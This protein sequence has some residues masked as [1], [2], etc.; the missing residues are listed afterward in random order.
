[1]ICCIPVFKK[2]TFVLAFL[3]VGS[4]AGGVARAQTTQAP[5]GVDLT[6][7][8]EVEQVLKA[9][10]G[11]D[12]IIL[13]DP[14][15]V[16]VVPGD[17]LLFTLTY[18]NQG[19]QPATGFRAINPVPAAVQFVSVDEDWAELS[20]DGGQTWGRLDGLKVRATGTDGVVVE[21]AAAPADVTHVRWI[22]AEPIASQAGGKV[23]FRA[24]VR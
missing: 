22:F 24:L 5:S 4:G 9:A 20:V 21:R 14:G 16:T 6:S 23:R 7:Q 11:T 2:T 8:I 13:A 10:D 18:R 1:M 19:A 12:K 15:N 3:A 17:N